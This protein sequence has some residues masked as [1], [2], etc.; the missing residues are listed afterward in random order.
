VKRVN[1]GR[2]EHPIRIV[3]DSHARTPTDAK[4]LHKGP[5]KRIIAVSVAAP[6]N[7]TANLARFADI[8]TVG[9]QQ[10][11]L[12]ELLRYLSK[13][14]IQRLMVEG[15]GTLIWSMISA[16]LVD[17]L[18]MFVGNIIIGGKDAPTLA[19]GDG[20]IKE[21]DFPKLER[22]GVIPMEE[23]V[24]IHWKVNNS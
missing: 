12:K 15:G 24:L 7:M 16:G 18:S 23:G 21:S 4:I 14:G 17:E 2:P 13:I 11:Y 6:E 22:I 20:Y 10:V 1:E 8:Y 3:I 9:I 5:G 19:D